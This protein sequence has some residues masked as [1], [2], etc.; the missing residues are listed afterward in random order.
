MIRVSAY[1][2][3][4]W[5][6]AHTPVNFSAAG[7]RESIARS[8]GIVQADGFASLRREVSSRLAR[9]SDPKTELVE[10][11]WIST[12]NGEELVDLILTHRGRRVG[13]RFS[14]RYEREV[15][16]S[17]ALTLVY[18][19]FDAL[20]RI[21]PSGDRSVGSDLAFLAVSMNPSWFSEDG[22]LR[23]GRVASEKALAA[24]EVMKRLGTVKIGEMSVLRIRISRAGE[25]VNDFERAL[26]TPDFR[27]Y[28]ATRLPR[29]SNRPSVKINRLSLLRGSIQR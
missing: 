21:R 6:A 8:A 1:P 22:R 17:D 4:E 5:L 27:T 25:W 16:Q 15:E 2:T 24:A 13:Y 11:E 20:Y 26:G 23:A 7:D 10:A 19:K 29:E 18:G 9:W 14:S 12:P 28:L 3:I